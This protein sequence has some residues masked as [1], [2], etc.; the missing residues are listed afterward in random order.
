MRSACVFSINNAYVIPFQVFFHSLEA[1]DSLPINIPIFILHSNAL[2]YDSIHIL[3]LFFARYG[4]HV[5]F[6]DASAHVPSNLPIRQSDHVSPETFFRLLIAE[7]LPDQFDHAI[8]LDADML[9]LRSVS[10]LFEE[11]VDC[12]IAAVD[13]FSL[14]DELRLWGERGGTYFQAGV[15]V[16]PLWR[17]RKE[18]LVQQFLGVMASE[19]HRILWHDQD[20]LNMV[21]RD[22]WARLPIWWNVCEAVNRSL[23]PQMIQESAVLIH[24][25]G[26]QKPW[27]AVCP[28]PFTS[29][30]DE[31]YQA[32]F[33]VPFDREALMPPS[34]PLRSRLNSALRARI[35]GL[36]YGRR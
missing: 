23:S 18:C 10:A 19:Q 34:P 27:N 35:A 6:L 1:T 14:W 25:S 7:I 36:I 28:S 31:C 11:T 26:S 17:W 24:Y 3:R 12:L 5:T 29:S 8:Y 2:S 4:R 21:V 22:R 13:H 20:I 32:T 30:W 15:L 33:G 16:I 9:A